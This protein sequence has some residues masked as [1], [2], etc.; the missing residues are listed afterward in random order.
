MIEIYADG[1]CKGNPGPGGW[2][3]LIVVDS[4]ETE[5]FGGAPQTTNN[6]ME[7]TAMIRSLQH[8]N[9]LS[10]TSV[11]VFLDSKYVLDGINDWMPSWKKK[12]WRT[13]TNK[14]VKNLELWQMLDSLLSTTHHSISYVWVKGHSGHWGNEKADQLANRG[15]IY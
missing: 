1:A 12:G 4:V 11:T 7:L 13:S 10:K 14:P 6:V 15:V 8:V 5:L 2:G 9:S 3:A